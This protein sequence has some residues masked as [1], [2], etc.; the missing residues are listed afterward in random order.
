M[1][2]GGHIMRVIALD[3]NRHK[4]RFRLLS[5]N[6]A[7]SLLHRFIV[8]TRR[9]TVVITTQHIDFLT[10]DEEFQLFLKIKKGTNAQSKML[11]RRTFLLRKNLPVR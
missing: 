8:I 10:L 2:E 6:N 5:Y 7:Q 1:E 11:S 4:L 3:L 9:L